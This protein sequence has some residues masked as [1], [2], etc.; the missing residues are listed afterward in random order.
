MFDD[1]RSFIGRAFLQSIFDNEF[2][3]FVDDGHDAEILARLKNW[4]SRARRTETQDE[5][6]F[7]TTFFEEIWGFSAT[8][9]SGDSEHSNIPKFSVA[10]A[11]AKGGAGAA[12]LALGWFRDGGDT[13]PQVLCEFKDIRSDLDAKQNRKG[14]NHS[15]VEQCLNYLKGARR[16]LFGNEPVQPWWGLVTDMNEFRLYWWDRAPREFMRFVIRRGKAAD[17]AELFEQRDL[18]GD[19]D[20]SAFDRFLFRK[21]LH[22]DMLI[23]PSGRPALWRLVERQ[24]LR[25][26]QIE[27]EFYAHYKAVRERLFNVLKLSNPQFP[28]TAVDLLRISQKLLDRFIFAFYCEDMGERMLFPPQFIRD[29]LAS[30]SKAAHYEADGEEIWA[31]FKR[32]FKYMHAGG[33]FGQMKVPHINGGLFND[34]PL[35]NGLTIPN[36]VFAAPGQGN[37][38]AA[39]LARDTSTLLY[40]SA[41]YNYAARGDAKESLSLYTLGR[42]FEQSITELEYRVG[43]LEGRDTI[44]K[45][46]KRKRDGVYY[47][48]EWVVNYLVEETLG[49]WFAEAKRATGYFGNETSPASAEAYLERLRA[50]RI[51]D[52]ACGSGAFLISAFR[53]LLDERKVLARQMANDGKVLDDAPIIAEILQRNIFGVDINPS[54]VEIA[55][56]ALWLHSARASAPLSSL[57]ETIR[58]GN[59]LV[60][61][62]C[63]LS[64]KRDAD[65]EARINPFDWGNETYDIVLGNPPYVKLQNLMKV[66]PDVVAYLRTERPTH[67]YASAQTGNFDLYLP[68]IELGLRLLA[69][70][71]KMAYIAPSVWAVN[72]YGQ[73][74]REKLH[75]SRQLER[76]VD[77]KSF[78]IFDEAITYT[79][80]QFFT[81]EANGALKAVVSPDGEL[82]GIDWS[83]AAIDL[84]YGALA[85]EAPWLMLAGEERSLIDR[86]A[87]ECLRLDNPRV[88][89]GIIV[90]IQTSADYIYHLRRT[91]HGAYECTP[92]KQ[93]SFVVEIEDAIMKPLVSGPEAKRYE[94]PETDTHLLFPYERDARGN[95]GLIPAQTMRDRFPNAWRHL[96]NFEKELRGRESGK[97]DHEKWY[98]Y[99]Y[100]KNL[101]KQEIEKLIVPRLVLGLSCS[102]DSDGSFY[103]D[104]VDVGGVV[105]VVDF[106]SEFLLSI[107][108]G[109]V[110]NFVFH[111]ISKPFQNGYWSANKQ[112]IAP[113]PV[114]EVDPQTQREVGAMARDLQERWTRRRELLK[115]AA[116]RLSTLSRKRRDEKW[117]W[118]DLPDI[119]TLK[120]ALPKRHGP[121]EKTALA[122]AQFKELVERRTGAL[123][124]ALDAG[125]RVEA[126]FVLGE[127]KLIVNGAPVLDRIFLDP[128]DGALALAHWRFQLLSRRH[129][130]ADALAKELR[131][132]PGEPAIAGA[133]QF[134]ERVQSLFAETLA[135]RDAET[136][137]N[138]RL[139][140]LYNLSTNER[141]LVE[142]DCA[143]RPLL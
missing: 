80:L 129:R 2:R 29:E 120:E 55:K 109:P 7:I 8:G 38:G 6:A 24:W 96:T 127:L 132:P 111:R 19:N 3:L 83:D 133:R 84:P 143:Q 35:I 70:G 102:L 118:P 36:H 97:M 17:Q 125:G 62:D 18:L 9:R 128:E 98:G 13:I 32:L 66:D 140:G 103:L 63:W 130:D 124:G 53:R 113:L 137:L 34:D 30:R 28:G 123:Q 5:S 87:R 4:D 49:P 61:P 44:A 45:L 90:G 94:T 58:C 23:A 72:E 25:E 105:P 52:P 48:P 81:A 91:G 142:R 88:T 119:E 117:L 41:R 101:D 68:F 1:N 22:R 31:F 77:F 10:G 85:L 74:L 126:E 89:S 60:A 121:G 131:R 14:S 67:S 69:P 56:L 138:N 51:L 141:S 46:S 42:I 110:A 15:P 79:A 82:G 134:V 57:D 65:S 64:I 104:N 78:Q 107:L 27:E 16:E 12:D 92:P 136:R 108:N 71:G 26:S 114:P 122:N 33:S 106:D 112:F 116:A 135:I 50:I 76:W 139:F 95:M 43:E 75:R 40:L 54:S 115:E 59:S 21:L 39:A 37:G 20:E 47:T 99:V 73:G 86:L 11:G 100:P 93:P